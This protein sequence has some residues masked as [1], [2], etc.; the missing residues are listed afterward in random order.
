M[1]R[2]DSRQG[3]A[4]F[5]KRE[6]FVT[7]ITTSDS[8]AA[9]L[10]DWPE[11]VPRRGVLVTAFG[12]QIPFSDFMTRS[13]MLLVERQNPD[14]MGARQILVK[15]EQV[16]ALKVTDVVQQKVFSKMGF[17]APVVERTKKAGKKS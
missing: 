2:G 14:T 17:Q 4:F 13:D 8:W 16:I 5:T 1:Q 9:L 6:V 7:A 15:Y 10:L 12:E 3:Y 11:D